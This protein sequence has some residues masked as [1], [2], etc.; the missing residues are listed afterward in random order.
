VQGTDQDS[1]H[2]AFY[3]WLIIG[4]QT[5]F[6][7]CELA[8]ERPIKNLSDFPKAEDPL[9]SIY[10]CLGKDIVLYDQTNRRIPNNELVNT[11]D[12]HLRG[13]TVTYRFQKNGDNGQKIDYAANHKDPKT[14]AAR[15]AKRIKLRAIRF[16]LTP[17]WPLSCYKAARG[18]KTPNWFHSTIIRALLQSMAMTTYNVPN[19]AELKERGYLFSSHSIR[20]CAT[21]MLHLAGAEDSFIQT[22]LRWKS[23]MFLIYLRNMPRLA[24]RHLQFLQHADAD[25]W[26][27]P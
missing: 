16:G 4:A 21:V 17:D 14:C 10:Q 12:E 13:F 19:S 26:D 1:K 22:R 27:L 2:R 5:G 24:V 20:V 8:S 25:S 9:R 23:S 6:R 3:D 15:A 7:R 11:P 18:T